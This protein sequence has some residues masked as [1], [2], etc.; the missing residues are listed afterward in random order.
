MK[1]K[2]LTLY[3][4]AFIA[5]GC[6]NNETDP[7]ELGITT[8]QLSLESE[9][10]GMFTTASDDYKHLYKY[11]SPINQ[12]LTLRVSNIQ[13]PIGGVNSALF[14]DAETSNQRNTVF[15]EVG[16]DNSEYTDFQLNKGEQI[17]IEASIFGTFRDSFY[18]FEIELLPSTENGL[19]QDELSLEPNETI[20][21]ANLIDLNTRSSSE[22]L[23]GSLDTIDAFKI[24][25][26]QGINYSL[27]TFILLGPSS[28]TIGG[29]QF[30][31]TDDK[32]NPITTGFDLVQNF[33]KNIEFSVSESGS[34]YLHASSPSRT[35]YQNSYYQYQ[36]AI[37]SPRDMWD[38]PFSGVNYEPNETAVTA[39]EIDVSQ[40]IRSELEVGG[41]DFIDSYKA[42]LYPGNQYQLDINAIAGPSRSSLSA[43][44]II[45]TDMAGERI[46]VPESAISVGENKTF[47]LE[48]MTETNT[49]IQL[50][51]SPTTGHELDYHEYELEITVI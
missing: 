18:E 23:T 37:W 2:F 19:A 49:I 30:E 31:L 26:E 43:L 40:H 24:Y 15:P 48:P 28:S 47:I 41:H 12:N 39:Y 3:I 20:N 51:Y 9:H 45:V 32:G 27:S 6:D 29:L 22:L 36:F 11:T 34:Y 17:T 21:I 33:G 7:D 13:G 1:T 16:Y 5:T 35:I 44:R 14:I 25:L 50:Y 38:N 46:L 8:T 4:S 42:T 10:I